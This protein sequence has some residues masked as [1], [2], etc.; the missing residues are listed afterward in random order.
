ML[1]DVRDIKTVFISPM[2]R[3]MQT[4]SLLFRRHPDLND[5]KFVVVPDLRENLCCSCD[6]PISNYQEVVTE[7]ES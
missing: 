7:F 6:I 4:A 5:I 1:K 3:T 2:R